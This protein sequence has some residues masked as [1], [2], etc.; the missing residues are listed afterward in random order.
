MMLLLML[1][2]LIDIVNF[3]T[4]HF[5]PLTTHFSVHVLFYFW[6]IITFYSC[7]ISASA[8]I[9]DWLLLLLLLLI[10]LPQRLPPKWGEPAT[11]EIYWKDFHCWQLLTIYKINMLDYV[12]HSLATS[13]VD[14]A[15]AIAIA[16]VVV[17]VF[18]VGVPRFHRE[19]E[20]KKK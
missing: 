15:I 13:N 2:L 7:C 20:K 5:I 11:E 3:E 16:I 18:I 8:I 14:I 19:R 10:L 4:M 1:I 17:V 12:L 6:E 9:A